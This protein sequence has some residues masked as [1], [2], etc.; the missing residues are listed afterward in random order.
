MSWARHCLHWPRPAEFAALWPLL[1]A[2]SSL[3]EA[4]R[5]GERSHGCERH[6]GTRNRL[7]PTLMFDFHVL[8][9]NMLIWPSNG[10]NLAFQILGWM[11]TYELFVWRGMN[12]NEK[13]SPSSCFAKPQDLSNSFPDLWWWR[14]G[15]FAHLSEMLESAAWGTVGRRELSWSLSMNFRL[16]SHPYPNVN[17]PFTG[18]L[19]LNS[20]SW[21]LPRIPADWVAQSGW[22]GHLGWGQVESPWKWGE[23][24]WQIKTNTLKNIYIY[25]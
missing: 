3:P 20:A 19:C 11:N 18:K 12:I 9:Q 14:H 6:W 22:K 2:K 5:S 15:P 24:S 17:G 8:P 4:S 1:S 7:P 21:P 16:L 25:I 13:Q 10:V 23:Q